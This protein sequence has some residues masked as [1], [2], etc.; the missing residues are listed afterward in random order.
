MGWQAGPGNL[1]HGSG[2]YLRPRPPGAA[3]QRYPV[4]CVGADLLGV[5]PTVSQAPLAGTTGE[6]E[7]AQ[8]W[9]FHGVRPV[10]R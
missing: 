1:Q 10:S 2:V 5:R 6:I 3:G 8:R 9:A 7:D 4:G